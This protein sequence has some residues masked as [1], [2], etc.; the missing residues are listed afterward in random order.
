LSGEAATIG[1]ALIGAV[2]GSVGASIINDWL[3]RRT[4]RRRIYE[5]VVQEYLLQLQDAIESLWHRFHNIEKL[6]GKITMDNTYFETTT[7]YVLA[8]VLAFKHV[9]ILEGVYYN[10]ERIKPGLGIFLRNKLEALDKRLDNM[11][12][13][14]N[15]K[16]SPFFRYDRQILAESV[17]NWEAD[18]SRIGTFIDFK[19]SYDAADSRIKLTLTPAREFVLALD[20]SNVSVIR[21]LLSDIALRLESETGISSSVKKSLSKFV[22]QEPGENFEDLSSTIYEVINIYDS[23]LTSGHNLSSAIFW[24][25]HLKPLLLALQKYPN[26]YHLAGKDQIP[27]LLKVISSRLTNDLTPSN[28]LKEIRKTFSGAISLLQKYIN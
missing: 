8:R 10:V 24:E 25:T 4:E 18:R 16:G 27:E 12:Y 9:I 23:Q 2:V 6:G 7:L 26:F 17:M 20:S 5:K 15:T 22:G 21:K 1:S 28:D 3:S 11:N 14:I 19:Q 13:E